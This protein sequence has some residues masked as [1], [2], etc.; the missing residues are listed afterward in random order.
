MGQH[1]SDLGQEVRHSSISPQIVFVS[2][3]RD[4]CRRSGCSVR[5]IYGP[6]IC[7][8]SLDVSTDGGTILTGAWRPGKPLELWDFG[9]GGLVEQIEWRDSILTSQPCLL[10]AA[11]FSKSGGGR[12]IAAGGSGANEARIFDRQAGTMTSHAGGGNALVGTVANMVRGVFSVD[13][14]PVA[15]TVAIGTGDGG[16]RLLNVVEKS[17]EDERVVEVGTEEAKQTMAA[18]EEVEPEEE[19]P[20]DGKYGDSDDDK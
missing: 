5:S 7:G 19:T 17:A 13:W 4:I 9:T 12:Y 1:N 16:I 8:D 2:R 15:D 10:Y 14:S 18:E 3:V 6:H 20:D 11:Q